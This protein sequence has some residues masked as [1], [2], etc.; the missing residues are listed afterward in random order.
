MNW[1]ERGDGEGR[2]GG[3]GV[4]VGWLSCDDQ[5]QHLAFLLFR[6]FTLEF[7]TRVKEKMIKPGKGSVHR[8]QAGGWPCSWGS[9][10]VV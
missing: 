3:L 6:Y 7:T 8:T 2:L 5:F 10:S 1:A 9:G 4:A